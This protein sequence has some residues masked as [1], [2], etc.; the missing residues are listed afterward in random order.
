M[1]ARRSSRRQPRRPSPRRGQSLTSGPSWRRRLV[2][3]IAVGALLGTV[4]LGAAVGASRVT[5]TIAGMEF[6]RVA[7]IKVNNLRYL[8]RATVLELAAIES[9]ASVW[10]DPGR[11]IERLQHNPLVARATIRRALPNTLVVRID[12]S[13]PV[14]LI[15][16]PTLGPIDGMGRVLPLDPALHRLDLPLLSASLDPAD[17]NFLSSRELQTLLDELSL[18]GQ[19]VPDLAARIS[20]VGFA[21]DGAVEV[22]MFSPDVTLLYRF[23]AT[24][25]RLGWGLQALQ[26]AR[27]RRPAS[28]PRVIDLRFGDQV[29]VRFA[30]AG[31]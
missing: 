28:V 14:A 16:T 13:T 8:D 22:H 15:S 29:V 30:G 24:A 1:S 20:S 25:E 27:R 5:A 18:L 7:D 12:E 11:W 19:I 23:P 26:D 21:P 2:R 3:L 4:A 31:V 6:F 9:D 10:D 17:S